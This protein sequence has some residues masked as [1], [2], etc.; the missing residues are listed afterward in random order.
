MSGLAVSFMNK[1]ESAPMTR[2]AHTPQDP[3]AIAHD[4]AN[5]RRRSLLYVTIGG[6][7]AMVYTVGIASP[8][9]TQFFLAIGANDFHFGIITG[10]PMLMLFMQFIGAAALNRA[11]RRKPLFIFCLILCRLIYLPVAFL[12][13]L[14]GAIGHPILLPVVIALLAISAATHNLAIPFWFSWMADLIPKRIMN[15]VWGARQKAM[16]TT[17][18]LVYLLVT[19]YL[20]RTA[21]PVTIVFPILATL[22]VIAGVI[23]ILLFIGVHEPPN[24]VVEGSNLATDFMAPLRHPLYRRFVGF[25][26]AWSFACH[27]AAAFMLVYALKVLQL[28]PWKASLIWCLQGVGMALASGMWGRLADRYGN[29]PV[30]KLCTTLKPMIVIVFFLATPQNVIWLLPLAFIPDGM[31]N[32]GNTLATNGYML[33]IAPRQNRSMFIAAITGLSGIFGG[34]AAITAGMLLDAISGWQG[35][36]A[37]Y[38]LNP[39]HIIFATSFLLR[40]LCQPLLWRIEEPGSH[41]TRQVIGAI[42]DE[43]PL[44]LVRFP[45]GLYRRYRNLPEA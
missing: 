22:A 12:P 13:F 32:A 35:S 30:L 4:S 36:I 3:T 41:H 45:V 23:D 33:S 7:L 16:H 19:V 31:F 24:L 44:W 26:C 28:E 42:M 5:M 29:R 38:A 6:C 34:V 8:A 20:Y 9:T 14:P 39:Y 11:R 40:L 2:R 37:G 25:S 1:L 21:Q 10:L 15:R 17:W 27:F 18:T 43:W